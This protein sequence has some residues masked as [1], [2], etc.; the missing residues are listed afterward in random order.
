MLVAGE[1]YFSVQYMDSDLLIPTIETLVFVG[2]N[3]NPRETNLLYFQDVECYLEGIKYGSSSYN[4]TGFQTCPEDGTKH[5]FEYER[6]LD[7]F[8]KCSLRRR[9][10]KD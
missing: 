4:D 2:R 3:L 7:E 10:A 6:A 9:S 1:T 5:I 8:M